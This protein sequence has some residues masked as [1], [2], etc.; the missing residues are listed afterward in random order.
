MPRPRKHRCVW[1]HPAATY[2]KPRGVPMSALEEVVLAVEELEAIRLRDLERLEQEEAAERMGISRPTFHRVLRSAREKTAEALIRGKALLI[3]G[4]DYVMAGT[5]I[6]RQQV[7]RCAGR[8]GGGRGRCG[9]GPQQ[10]LA[11]K[12]TLQ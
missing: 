1:G 3:H 9:R 4:G 7:G 2:F 12:E 11:T 5:D 6:A 10:D 8:A